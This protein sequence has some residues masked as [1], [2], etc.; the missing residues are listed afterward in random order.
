MVNI[1]LTTVLLIAIPVRVLFNYNT[2]ACAFYVRCIFI[3][4]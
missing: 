2:N 3:I 4:D 1:D